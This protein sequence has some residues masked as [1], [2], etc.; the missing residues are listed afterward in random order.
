MITE[1]ERSN[2][3]FLACKIKQM[4]EAAVRCEYIVYVYE[5]DAG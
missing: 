3:S 2:V 4:Y 1:H 5:W